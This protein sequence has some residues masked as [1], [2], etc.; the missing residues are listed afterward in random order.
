MILSIEAF[1][2]CIC[3]IC[4]KVNLMWTSLY[5]FFPSVLKGNLHHTLYMKLNAF[6]FTLSARRDVSSAHY[7]RIRFH[8]ELNHFE[9]CLPGSYV[10]NVSFD[11]RPWTGNKRY[12]FV[13]FGRPETSDTPRKE[14]LSCGFGDNNKFA[15]NM[16]RFS[17]SHHFLRE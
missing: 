3:Q 16:G 15:F 8:P 14:S 12:V 13:V 9:S 7:D 10:Q 6:L 2:D 11:K 5:V 1:I 4:W 17:T